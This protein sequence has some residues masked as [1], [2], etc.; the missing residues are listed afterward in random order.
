MAQLHETILHDQS[1]NVVFEQGIQQTIHI[2]KRKLSIHKTFRLRRF[3]GDKGKF[4][5]SA[6]NCSSIFSSK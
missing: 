4:K 5:C 6:M 3:F 1:F 2:I